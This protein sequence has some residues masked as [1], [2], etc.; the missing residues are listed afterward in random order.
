MVKKVWSVILSVVMVFGMAGPVC[1]DGKDSL[2]GTN[3]KDSMSR[4][5][6]KDSLSNKVSKD[7]KDVIVLPGVGDSGLSG[8]WDVSGDDS[9]HSITGKTVTWYLGDPYDTIEMPVYL[10]DGVTDL[11]YVDLNDWKEIMVRYITS[12]GDIGET[13]SLEL[14]TDDNLAMLTR[15]NGYSMLFDFDEGYISFED[16]DAFS[17]IR[18]TGTLVGLV[19]MPGVNSEGEPEL[20]QRN[21]EESFDRYGK[22]LVLSLKDYDINM[23]HEDGLYLVPL[24]TLGDF[25][26]AFPCLMDTL[27]NGKSVIIGSDT[28][29]IDDDGEQTILGEK[30]YKGDSGEKSS[31]LAW[32]SYCELCMA[33]DFFYGQKEIHNIESFDTFFNEMGFRDG[34]CSTDPVES[35]QT[36]YRVIDVYLDDLHSIF[37]CTSYLIDYMDVP[38]DGGYSRRQFERNEERFAERR[39]EAP[40]TITGYQEVGNTAYVTFDGFRMKRNPSEYYELTDEDM[41]EI[42]TLATETEVKEAVMDTMDLLIYAH[43]QITREDSPI[44]NVVLDLSNNTG[45]EIDAGVMV[46]GWFL[47]EANLSIS[48]TMTGATSTAS[49]KT[50]INLD[51]DFDETDT[52]SNLN[53]YC[54]ISPVSFSCGNMVPSAFQSSHRVTLLGQT[55]GGGSCSVLPMTSA[56]GSC[57]DISSPMHMSVVKNGSY[58]DIDRGVQPDV[59]ISNIDNYYDR[60][61]LTDFINRMA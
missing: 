16:F 15:D 52:V 33:L 11:P 56:Y 35:D 13:Y 3:G 47:G 43:R 45:G 42:E 32:Y 50:D 28:M 27:Y 49:Y 2:S 18:D 51:R 57:F 61:S 40:K 58:Y 39:S 30:Y 31:E 22:E 9:G 5:D 48:N 54:L 29:I 21:A 6:G 59:Y 8:E 24:Q 34:L 25:M 53:L 1:A 41:E 17:Q 60:E 23:Y 4:A 38:T 37:A 36:L 19:S 20:V 12:Y 10:L 26:L 44:E 14:E 46:E 7:D 55:S